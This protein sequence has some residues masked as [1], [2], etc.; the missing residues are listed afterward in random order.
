MKK[1]I[2]IIV[3]GVMVSSCKN[4]VIKEKELQIVIK[5]ND[6]PNDEAWSIEGH[7]YMVRTKDLVYATNT[8]YQ[9]GD[10]LI[11]GKKCAK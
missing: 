7:K 2:S 8:L 11:V 9:V 3:L 10:T 1:L 4:I 5:V 6:M